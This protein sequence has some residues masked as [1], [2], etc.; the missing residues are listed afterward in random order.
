MII[1]FS[2]VSCTTTYAVAS[3]ITHRCVKLITRF[4]LLRDIETRSNN[5]VSKLDPAFHAIHFII[6]RVLD[7]IG[8]EEPRSC[9]VSLPCYSVYGCTERQEL[10]SSARR[11]TQRGRYYM[12]GARHSCYTLPP[13][14]KSIGLRRDGYN[15]HQNSKSSIIIQSIPGV[16]PMPTTSAKISARDGYKDP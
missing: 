5:H 11:S 12:C 4:G 14:I 10:A 3:R 6:L 1:S 7:V 13:R 15:F 8:S 2:T 16:D 9:T